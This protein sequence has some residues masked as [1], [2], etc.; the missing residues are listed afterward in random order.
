MELHDAC[1]P[2]AARVVFERGSRVCSN[3]SCIWLAWAQLEESVGN[4]DAAERLFCEAAMADPRD[5]AV[6]HDW[7]KMAVRGSI[8][9]PERCTVVRPNVPAVD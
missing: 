9:W 6:W 3:T 7:G 5:A 2:D 4:L 1:D 8:P